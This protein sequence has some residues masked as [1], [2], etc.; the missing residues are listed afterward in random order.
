M[1]ADSVGAARRLLSDIARS[2]WQMRIG[3]FTVREPLDS[4]VGRLARHLGCTYE[5]EFP[6]TG[7]MM[8]AILNRPGLLAKLQPELR[9][10]DGGDAADHGEGNGGKRGVPAVPA[11]ADHADAVLAELSR[12]ELISDDRLLIRL[13]LGYSSAA[14][15]PMLGTVI[16]ERYRRIF[17]EWFPGGGSA[18]LPVSYAHTLD[19]Y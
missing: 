10:R 14:D 3:E 8:A 13:L 16:P 4:L 5:Q 18:R 15:A 11:V 6:P 1:A 19:R 9:R 17:S 2:A 12:G 7:G